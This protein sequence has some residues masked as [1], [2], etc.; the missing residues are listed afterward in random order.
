MSR[1]NCSDNYADENTHR[2]SDRTIDHSGRDQNLN[3]FK[4][5]CIENHPNTLRSSAVDLRSIIVDNKL[6]N[7]F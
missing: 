3:L 2:I 6:Q 7:H 5:S 4:H 1:N